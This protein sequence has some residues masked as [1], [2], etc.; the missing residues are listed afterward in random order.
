MECMKPVAPGPSITVAYKDTLLGLHNN[1]LDLPLLET[2]FNE[3]LVLGAEDFMARWQQ[4]SGPGQEAAEVVTLSYALV[5]SAI[6]GA[7]TAVSE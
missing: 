6:L 4:L 3:P 2:T 7:M 5:P 1:T